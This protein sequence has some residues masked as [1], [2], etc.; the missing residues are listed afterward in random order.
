M[1]TQAVVVADDPV[2][3][4][5]LQNAAGQSTDFSLLRPLDADDL[6][7]RIQMLGRVDIVFFSSTRP[8][9]KR[10]WPWSSA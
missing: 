7:E 8:T 5:W 10:G 3:V 6:I 4:S 9:W 1:K 2:Y